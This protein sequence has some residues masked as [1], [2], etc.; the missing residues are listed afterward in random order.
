MEEHAMRSEPVLRI[1]A[2][3]GLLLVLGVCSTAGAL[4]HFK[5]ASSADDEVFPTVCGTTVVY[6]FYSSRYDDWEIQ[7]ADVSDP[8]LPVLFPITDVPGTDA[9][10]VIDGN[11]VVWQHEYRPGE[12][13]D[14][15]AADISNRHAA[16]RYVIAGTVHDERVPYVS[17]GV[18]VWQHLF[19]GAPDT[20]V[21][22]ARLTGQDDPNRFPVAASIDV[23][24][25]YPCISGDLVVWNQRM[26][27]V[28]QASLWGADISDP[29]NPRSFF[30][31]MLLGDHEFPSISNGVVVGRETDGDG[32]VM[33]DNLFDPFN[34]EQIS[35]SDRTACPKIHRHVVVWHEQDPSSRAW[36]IR[37]YNVRTGQEIVVTDRR[38]S[39]Q[40]YPSVYA[41]PD[42]RRCIVVWQDNR[43]GNWDV[44]AA[45]LDAADLGETPAPT[46]E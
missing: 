34:P 44:Y 15:H 42:S 43:D 33:L 31:A 26:P 36:N 1:L 21:F 40:M 17:G 29:N 25:R 12:D 46:Q 39:D 20:D 7:G 24:E 5:V 3:R 11:D 9:Y 22:G 30:T 28:P 35:R 13:W 37:A 45:I 2:V 18:V 19:V 4:T 27:N 6:Q 41:E 23:D 10:P 8:A 38:M 32:K 16:S 14:I